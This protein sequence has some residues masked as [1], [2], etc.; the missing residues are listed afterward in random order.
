MTGPAAR[1][2]ST[3]MAS[4]APS[5]RSLA[6]A[7][8]HAIAEARAGELEQLEHEVDL[9]ALLDEVARRGATPAPQGHGSGTGAPSGR[10]PDRGVDRPPFPDE[11]AHGRRYATR[12]RQAVTLGARTIDKRTPGGR[13]DGRAYA[14]GQAQCANGRPVSTH[15]WRISRRASAP[16]E[17]P[18]VALVIDTSG[19]MGGFE[20]AL[21]PIAWILT[22]GL[23]QIAGR[24][25][26]ALFGSSAELLTDGGERL[27]L[28]P[29]ICA[30]GGTAFA[31]D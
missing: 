1:I 7:L 25:A 11:I 31:R 18:H 27:T 16:I 2:G 28:V 10:L 22:D 24:C 17:A 9:Q 14:R 5:A 3:P 19:S 20:Y 23:R 13:F 26:I 6:A 21:G 8:E 4:G 29:G 30:G 15:P 12:L